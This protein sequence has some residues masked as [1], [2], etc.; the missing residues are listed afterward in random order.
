MISTSADLTRKS[1]LNI[2]DSSNGAL[3]LEVIEERIISSLGDKPNSSISEIAKDLRVNRS[4]AS[5]YL[6]VLRAKKKVAFRQ[7]GPVK[8]W[9][10][11][12]Q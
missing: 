5:K 2:N 4:T 3:L 10:L 7:V 12:E 6:H 11:E 1:L 8:L 9:S